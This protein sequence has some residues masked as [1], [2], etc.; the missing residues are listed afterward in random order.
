MGG[1]NCGDMTRACAAAPRLK[2]AAPRQPDR[3]KAARQQLHDL[4]QQ[5]CGGDVEA[6]VDKS[7]QPHKLAHLGMHSPHPRF[8]GRLR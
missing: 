3:V 8:G 4:S 5:G 6:F 7:R 2:Q 1:I